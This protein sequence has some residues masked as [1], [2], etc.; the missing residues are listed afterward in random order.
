L[1]PGNHQFFNKIA[2]VW[3]E[4]IGPLCPIPL[5]SRR[6]PSDKF[7]V[8]KYFPVMLYEQIYAYMTW[9]FVE[10]S[11]EDLISEAPFSYRA[12]KSERTQIS[13]KG[14]VVMTLSSI[15]SRRFIAKISAM[16]SDGAQLAMA[17]VTGHFKHGTE[18]AAKH[19]RKR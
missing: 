12:T 7:I 8:A 19:A 2:E 14:K 5:K 11:R 18:R 6:G 13:Y 9:V 10:M 17:K 15:E 3:S 1:C 16:D 4:E